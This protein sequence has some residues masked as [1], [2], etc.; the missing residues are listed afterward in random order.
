MLFILFRQLHDVNM[1]NV[2]E[3]KWPE[4]FDQD[5]A[6]GANDYRE[7]YVYGDSILLWDEVNEEI[8]TLGEF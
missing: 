5:D 3:Y 1:L 8:Q 4:Q 7:H 2:I 6:Y